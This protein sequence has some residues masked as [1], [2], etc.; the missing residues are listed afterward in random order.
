MSVR[1]SGAR[2]PRTRNPRR[3]LTAMDEDPHWL[4]TDELAAWR[5]F[6]SVA[7]ELVRLLDRELQE[8]SGVTLDDYGILSVV[9]TEPDQRARFSDVARLLAMPT[10]T[11][12][13][14]CQR[15]V[16]QGLLRRER[17]DGDGRGGWAVLTDDGGALLRTAARGHV[18]DVRRYFLDHVDPAALPQL[19]AELERVKQALRELR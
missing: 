17:V 6:I 14:R 19:G 15:L 9:S 12:S 8:R 7:T 1:R 13:Y 11:V 4:D 16:A 10:S 18:A 3:S 5:S 2:G